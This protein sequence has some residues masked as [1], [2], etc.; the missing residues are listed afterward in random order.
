MSQEAVNLMFKGSVSVKYSRS[1][2]ITDRFDI[3]YSN[4]GLQER[5]QQVVT[6]VPIVGCERPY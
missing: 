4:R 1:V 5:K 6:N 3:C 2:V